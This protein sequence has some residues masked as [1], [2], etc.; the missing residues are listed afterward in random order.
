MQGRLSGL[1]RRVSAR[2][3]GARRWAG[4][5]FWAVM[6]QGLFAASNFT[7]NIM[8]ARWLTPT[9]YG[10][11]SVAY[12]LFLLAGTFHTAALTEPMLVFGSGKYKERF[13]DYLRVLLR[14]HWRFGAGLVAVFALGGLAL[15]ALGS[16][17]A[18]AVLALAAAG[19][20]ILFQWL[21]RR[22]CY[23]NMQPHFAAYAGAAYM[24]LMISSA[25]GLYYYGLLSAVT[26]FGVMA[27]ASLCS[28]LWLTTK[29]RVPSLPTDVDALA[30]ASLRDHWT[31]G[32]WAAGIAV[33]T[34][35]PGNAFLL[36][37]PAWWGLEA[38]GTYR[39]LLNLLLPMMNVTTALGTVL[40]PALVKRRASLNGAFILR[41]TLLFMLAPVAYWALLG[42]FGE[43]IIQLLYGDKYV[44]YAPLLPL[45]ALI[46]VLAAAATVSSTALR[47]LERP[48][49][50]FIAS[51]WSTGVTLT[52]GLWLV[53]AQGVS[54]ALLGWLLAYTVT[55]GIL[56]V[57]FTRNAQP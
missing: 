12:T 2:G 43:P 4:K 42:V 29:L 23:V 28:G 35:V 52:V 47:A 19:P 1:F 38:S 20:L 53:S 13:S 32:R 57:L 14:G 11:F 22:A 15:W 27:L 33:L 3:V 6:D 55:A 26:G 46:P 17:L 24:A 40:L 36:V 41:L 5:G 51:A 34:W 10:A 9:D 54:G 56:A 16:S 8:L 49:K 44:G 7:L 50:A 37:L 45:A 48:N 18:P 25:L 21:M 30:S 39:A 31:Y